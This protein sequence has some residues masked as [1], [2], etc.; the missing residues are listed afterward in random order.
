M[1]FIVARNASSVPIRNIVFYC[2]K[3]FVVLEF[4]KLPQTDSSRRFLENFM[5]HRFDY[6]DK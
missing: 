6:V 5:L 2:Y 1:G 4:F 3:L